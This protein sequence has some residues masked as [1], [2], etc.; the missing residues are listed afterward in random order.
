MPIRSG[1]LIWVLLFFLLGIPV[2][3]YAQ[4]DPATEEVIAAVIAATE[5]EILQSLTAP[6]TLQRAE[7]TVYPCVDVG[8]LETSYERLD[9]I[10]SKTGEAHLITEQVIYCGGLGAFGLGILRWS[11]NSA[12]LYFTDGREGA[13]DG[14]VINWTPPVLRVQPGDWQIERLGAGHFSR[15]NL[16]LAT[17]SQGKISI[18]PTNAADGGSDFPTLPAD[19][20]IMDV[21]WLP[22]DSGVIY[23]QTDEPIA[24]SRSTVTHIDIETSEQTLLLDN[25]D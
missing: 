19:L 3:I 20:L 5:P 11:D 2:S 7:V 16:W 24:S 10:D 17:W 4:E 23:I 14:L 22:D 13:P 6:D 9:V 12:F 8:G 25:G 1:N 18:L 15:N 21:L